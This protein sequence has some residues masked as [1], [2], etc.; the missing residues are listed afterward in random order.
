MFLINSC[1]GYFRCALSPS[2]RERGFTQIS[3]QIDADGLI[4]PRESAFDPRYPR[5]CPKDKRVALYRRYGR[6]FAEFLK[7]ESLVPLGLLALS[8]CVGLR[9]GS[10]I[11]NSKRLFLEDS[12]LALAR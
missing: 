11:L 6:F 12:S 1:Q 3:M 10:H 7:D 4:H 8:T 9:Y 5:S 2:G